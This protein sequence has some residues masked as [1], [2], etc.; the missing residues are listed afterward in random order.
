MSIQESQAMRSVGV[1]IDNALARLQ[2]LEGLDRIAFAN[3]YKEWL[4]DKEITEQIW[5][6][7]ALD[8]QSD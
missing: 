8:Q 5:F 3:E 6:S 4:V 7:I 1:A 2:E